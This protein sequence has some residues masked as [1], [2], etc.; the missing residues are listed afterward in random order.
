MKTKINNTK[1]R[2]KITKDML[3]GDIVEKFPHSADVMRKNGM[4]CVGCCI[5]AH[6]TIEQGAMGHGI[7]TNVLVRDINN[8]IR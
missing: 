8:S 3:I 7:D 1:K 2:S 6:E 5:S 4:H